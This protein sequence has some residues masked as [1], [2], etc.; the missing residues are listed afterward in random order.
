MILPRVMTAAA[1]SGSGKTI[2][3]CGLL[4]ALKR[5]GIGVRT[6]KCGPDYIDPMFHRMVTGVPRGTI[7]TFFSG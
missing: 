4:E 1:R 6:Y 2:I 5:R 3:T 7:D